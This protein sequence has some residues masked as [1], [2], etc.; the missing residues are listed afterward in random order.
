MLGHQVMPGSRPS[1]DGSVDQPNSATP[2]KNDPIVKRV[3]ADGPSLIAH[4]LYA[5]PEATKQ[6]TDSGDG[7]TLF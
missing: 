5:N 6:L 1:R 7:E 2:P 3:Y 4:K